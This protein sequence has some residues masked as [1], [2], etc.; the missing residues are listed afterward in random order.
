MKK[1]NRAIHGTRL[2]VTN[3]IASAMLLVYGRSAYA[4]TCVE[5][6]VAS[7]NW[8]CSGAAGPDVTQPII[9]APV[10]V[11]TA[12]GFG[13][14]T[15]IDNAITITGTGGLSFID[16]AA[17]TITGA[18]RGI[19]GVNNASGNLTIIT[20]GAIS[21]GTAEGIFARNYGDGDT[22]ILITGSTVTGNGT[23]A[24]SVRNGVSANDLVISNSSNITGD[25]NGILGQNFG[26]G[27][28]TIIS[29]GN[30]TGINSHGIIAFNG[31]TTT[32]LTIS[33]SGNIY[34]G[35]DAISYGNGATIINT[36]GT[37]AS[38]LSGIE[39][40]TGATTTDLTVIATNGASGGSQGI[41]I[42]HDG[43]GAATITS[44]GMVSGNLGY[45]IF[46]IA[47]GTDLTITATDVTGGQTGINVLNLG[48]GASTVTSSGTV[49]GTLRNGIYA[50]NGT[51][52]NGLTITTN[53]VTGGTG[54]IL[55]NNYGFGATTINSTGTVS[56]DLFGISARNQASAGNLTI[57]AHNIT[58]AIFGIAAVNY[59]SSPTT[60]NL[61]GAITGGSAFGIYSV[62]TGGSLTTINLASTSSVSSTFGHAIGNYG[63]DSI[64][65]VS[66][67]AVINGSVTLNEGS[68]TVNIAGGTNLSGI[69]L[70]DGGDDALLGDGFVD[71]LNLN[72]AWSGNLNGANI[73]NWEFI[74]INGGNV[75]FSDS[76]ITAGQ[77][78]VN[79]FGSLNGSNN[80]SIT[81][82]AA[83]A[84]GSR[85]IA[86]NAVG[87]N[88]M[89][90][91]GNLFNA[92]SVQ[93]NGPTGQQATGDRLTVTGNYVGGGGTLVLDTVLNNDASTTDR[94]VVVGNTS[95]ST[96]IVVN[97]VGGLGAM[98][99]GDGIMLVDVAGNSAAN[100][101]NLNHSVV[102]G[103]F[104]YRLYQNGIVNTAD[105]DWYLRSSARGITSP[106]MAIPDMG[107]K[108]GLSM[109]GSLHE[110]M[111]EKDQRGAWIRVVGNS[112]QQML[113]SSIGVF[114]SRNDSYFIQ[115]GTDL[116]QNENNRLGVFV[117]KT[118]SSAHMFDAGIDTDAGVAK[119]D[120]YAIG[121][122]ATH[123]TDTY[124][125]D[126]VIQHSWLDAT[127]NG[128][129]DSYKTDSKH[130]LAS[131]E[132]GRAFKFG[133]NNSLEPQVQIIAGKGSTDDASDGFT[134]Y[135]YSSEDVLVGRLGVLWTHAKGSFVPFL[136]ANVSRNFGDD[137]F[138]QIGVSDIT[139]E[140][141]DTWGEI[142]I[143]F[144]VLTRH[145]WSIFMQYDY[146]KGLGQ[147]DLENHSG[148]IGLRRNW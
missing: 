32:D 120:G 95:G 114:E 116:Y 140:R 117:A 77:I 107:N 4:G 17:S 47:T 143:G 88:A 44:S 147:T 7:G 71:M 103:A 92:G 13:I 148:T 73:L 91:S 38:N 145:N 58:G 132:F 144:S 121:A 15:S 135:N 124:Y 59:G 82:N 24:I 52:A 130:W 12:P 29:T 146:E 141:N 112:G 11:T 9:G 28:T 16:T 126:A 108:L 138:V 2:V 78:N 1:N 41:F 96:G 5:T 65:N 39:A 46:G 97:N 93:L 104:N 53:N 55:A 51:T 60:I 40:R 128:D 8:V 67:G 83:V 45:G 22:A 69:T 42:S 94:L 85:I 127:A 31:V 36:T 35:I 64:V 37:V 102:A 66:S 129:G 142:G 122:Y 75:G 119:A 79:N 23:A 6:P 33:S 115:A 100:A 20:T 25:Q 101:F 136:K 70:L 84:S 90:I 99:T 43:T 74:N 81:G 80:L 57:S 61:S 105:G 76:A 110:R 34:G 50:S 14:D 72:S 123:R 133:N 27:S 49:T 54:G 137:S 3:A 68:D 87:S 63:G 118:Q 106:A 98:T 109:L 111:S 30:V 21:G 139:T 18:T 113:E 86:G 10:T 62:T 56:A 134:T 131:F 26:T 19:E 48:T 89:S 125:W